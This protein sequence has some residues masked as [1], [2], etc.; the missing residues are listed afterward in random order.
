MALVRQ[1][2]VQV[3]GLWLVTLII[4]L[5]AGAGSLAFGD[6]EF[7]LRELWV[8][9]TQP[10]AGVKR[11]VVFELRLPRYLIALLA[12]A[13]LGVAG[14][15]VQSITRNPLS[16]PSLLGVS[17]GA[18]FAI[19][20][21]FVWFD[22]ETSSRLLFGTAGGLLAAI[23][24]FSIAWKTHLSPI[25]LTLA[26]MSIALF[27]S[28]GI[29][30]LLVSAETDA[31]GIYYWLAGSLANL[32]WLHVNQLLPFVLVVLPLSVC[33]AR[34]LNML[35]L[36]ENVA[37]SSGVA[38]HWWRLL[39]GMLAVVLTAAT[40]SVTGPVSFVGLIA[41]HIVRLLIHCNAANEHKLLLPLSAMV[42]AALVS[43][44]DL[45]AKLQEVPVGILCILI[46]GP[47]FV[48]L[49]RKQTL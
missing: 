2:R 37:R 18:A 47:L 8:A 14:T 17:S 46:G 28:A 45:L 20:A 3:L 42:G 7:S 34:P 19:V 26:G 39:L 41:P 4:I 40:V 44:A 31:R 10:S 35:M 11:F 15:I 48:C 38:V 33:L 30:V 5:L 25:H 27:F 29:T 43:A 22:F 24:T 32:T 1:S 6:F 12:G 36:E 49:I 16:S 23:L 21:S 9:L 13:A